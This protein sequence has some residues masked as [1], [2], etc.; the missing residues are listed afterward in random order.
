MERSVFSN[1]ELNI[2]NF[3]FPNQ[4]FQV[5]Q[6]QGY[7]EWPTSGEII[8][9]VL[10]NDVHSPFGPNCPPLQFAVCINNKSGLLPY[11]K[12]MQLLKMFIEY[13]PF[14]SFL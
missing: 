10:K 12:V 14:I 8:L 4:S 3:N 7:L 1:A 13:L 2:T 9:I 6:F 5:G 11:E